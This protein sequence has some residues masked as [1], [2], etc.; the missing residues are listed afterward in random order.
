VIHHISFLVA[1][2]CASTN[3][4]GGSENLSLLDG[5]KF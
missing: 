1:G 3:F 5:K 2:A 4:V